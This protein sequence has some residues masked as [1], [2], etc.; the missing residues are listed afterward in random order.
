M[1]IREAP[2]L[3]L[4]NCLRK[5]ESSTKVTMLS[6]HSDMTDGT[7]H[8]YI[9]SIWVPAPLEQAVCLT[10]ERVLGLRQS[11]GPLSRSDAVHKGWHICI[12]SGMYI[13]NKQAYSA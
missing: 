11:M 13:K 5:I 9:I 3:C 8:C 2:Q 12:F 4:R 7:S 10:P 1:R 6:F